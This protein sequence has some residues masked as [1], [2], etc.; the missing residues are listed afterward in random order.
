MKKYKYSLILGGILVL[1]GVLLQLLWKGV[2]DLT[3]ALFIVVG[4]GLISSG[5]R[6]ATK[7]EV[8][9]KDERVKKIKVYSAYYSWII[10][11]LFI[12]VLFLLLHFQ[13]VNG[14]VEH[15]L[16]WV[17]SV[18]FLSLLIPQWYLERK[19]DVE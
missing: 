5:L 14:D 9:E 11:V 1:I 7:R 13:V 17:Y 16:A 3:T 2:D 15:V 18:M 8:A 10:T 4:A 19:G 12:S 6:M